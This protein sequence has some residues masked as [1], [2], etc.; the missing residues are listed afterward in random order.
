MCVF[1]CLLVCLFVCVCVCVWLFCVW[2]SG[3]CGGGCV[4]VV[5]PQTLQ[6][7]SFQR[8]HDMHWNEGTEAVGASGFVCVQSSW[9]WGFNSF[10]S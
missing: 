5:A 10:W 7:L 4:C 1:V 3:V 6:Q 8:P 9:V 2:V